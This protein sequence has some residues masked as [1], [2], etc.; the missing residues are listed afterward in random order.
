MCAIA[1]IILTRYVTTARVQQLQAE[2]KSLHTKGK[3][4]LKAM[5]LKDSFDEPKGLVV[6]PAIEDEQD[7]A[8][9]SKHKLVKDLEDHVRERFLQIGDYE[10]RIVGDPNLLFGLAVA[11][12]GDTAAVGAPRF[13]IPSV[14]SMLGRVYMF[15]HNGTAWEQTQEISPTVQAA[16]DQFGISVALDNGRLVVGAIQFAT[17]IAQGNGYACTFIKNADGVWEEEDRLT[18]S[19]GGASNDYFGF[20]VAI[21]GDVILVGTPGDNDNGNNSGAAYYFSRAGSN[22]SWTFRQKVS[23]LPLCLHQ[24]GT[25]TNPS[26]PSIRLQRLSQM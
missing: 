23:L 8:L 9:I 20:S 6:T 10:G 25:Y 22:S 16:G 2:P 24:R 11:L 13:Y 26:G 17:F 14:G 12:D 3:N 5:P 1:E 21:Q 19:G 7:A 4:S 18:A 15:V